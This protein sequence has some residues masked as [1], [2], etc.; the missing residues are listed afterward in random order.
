MLLRDKEIIGLPVATET[1]EKLGRL[2][3]LILDV[4]RH[5]VI[6]YVVDK[7]GLLSAV[8]P[9]ELVVHSSMVVSIDAERIVVRSGAVAEVGTERARWADR[10]APAGLSRAERS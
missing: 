1:G 3:G 6:D 2:A 10:P 4:D 7:S 9:K 5:A 8:L